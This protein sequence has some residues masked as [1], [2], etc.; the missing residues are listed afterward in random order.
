MLSGVATD[1][2]LKFLV[3]SPPGVGLPG[4]YPGGV[5]PGTGELERRAGDIAQLEECLPSLDSS[6]VS[7]KPGVV[8]H[9]FNPAL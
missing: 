6:S 9:V 3:V 4:V 7:H 1:P 2:L 8:V 5:L